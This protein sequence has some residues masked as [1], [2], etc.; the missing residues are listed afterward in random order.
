MAKNNLGNLEKV[1]EFLHKI[2]NLKS[3]LRYNKTA[4]GRAESV[5]DHSWR[6]ALM[7][8]IIADE[9]KLNID[10]V[11]SIKMALV[12]DLAEALTGDI[13]AILIA[14]GKVS[15]ENKN[16]RENKA[17]MELKAALPKIAGKEILDLW[18]EYNIGAAREAKFVKALDKI[19]TLTQ[20]AESGYKTY[21]KPEFIANY[22][23]KHVKQ[24]PELTEMLQILKKKLKLEFKK[25]NIKWKEEYDFLD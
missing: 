4:S 1:F 19:E 5:A 12:H 14:E 8:F 2:E 24:F 11:K 22:A 15:V 21:D 25:G 3:T 10:V 20:L 6:L 17:I 9:L 23:D 7:T 18:K 13:D 16:R